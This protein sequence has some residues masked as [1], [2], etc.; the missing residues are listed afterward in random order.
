MSFIADLLG[1]LGGGDANNARALRAAGA[2]V[3]DVRSKEEWNEG[4][5]DGA[6]WVPLGELPKR[7]NEIEALVQHD[8]SK[9]VVVVCRSG[10]R[11]G[12]ARTLLQQQGFTHVVNGGGWTALR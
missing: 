1:R 5:L 6:T 7:L 2:P 8:K 3:V 11:A 4:H 10:G 12:Q 9:P